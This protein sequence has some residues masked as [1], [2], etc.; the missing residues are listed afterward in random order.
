MGWQPLAAEG[1]IT[2]AAVDSH[3]LE[4]TKADFVCD[5]KED[6]AELARSLSLAKQGKALIDVD[7]KTQREVVASLNHA[8][9]WLPGTYHLS[10]TLEIP[11]AVNCVLDAEGTTLRW[12][13]Q[14]GDAVVIRGMNRCRY[15]FGTIESSSSGVALRI[16]PNQQMP[17]L[18]S[19]VEFAGLVGKNQQGIGL[20]LDPTS[21]NVC[22]N[23]FTGTDISGFD[24]GVYV[25]AA[26]D[27]QSAAST[28][29]KCDTNWFW[30]SYVRLC[31]TCIRESATGVDCSVWDVNVDASLPDSVAIRAAG[32]YGKWFVIMGTYTFEKKNLAIV[33]EPGAQHCVFAVH[34]PLENFRW[35]DRSQS[36]TNVI[37]TTQPAGVRPWGDLSTPES[38]PSATP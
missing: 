2:V 19:F 26:G 37:L 32:S 33:L 31:H 10:E 24:Q 38:A 9:R 27:R 29:G 35:E 30:L 4:K 34:P 22:V 23:R 16:Q 7:P 20:M 15:R 13:G 1:A 3:D 18:R 6:Q 36:S 28:H 11:D 21:E 25:G 12:G 8:V 5:G 14:A 17:A